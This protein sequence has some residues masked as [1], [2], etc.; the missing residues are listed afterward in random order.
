MEG[1]KY[2]CSP[3]LRDHATQKML[4]K[5]IAAGTF[6][7]VSSDH[8]PYRYDDTGKF[9][10]GSDIDFRK[11]ANGMP[12][13]EMRLPMMF[14]E[15]VLKGRIGLNQFVALSSTN[16]AKLYGMH[17]RKGT[18]SVG[19]D[20]DIA[21]W[22]PTEVRIAGEMHDNMDYNPFE[23]MEVTGWPVTVLGRGERIVDN[24][25]LIAKPG[26]GAFIAR[27]RTDLTGLSGTRLAETNLSSNFGA[28]VLK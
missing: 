15:G 12:G 10:A 22:D 25:E 19:A 23:G 11:I 21:I 24:G 18:L 27:D 8:A 20:A 4:W 16:A 13:I 2:I 3:P 7:V 26:D 5:H 1:A 9:A 17:P 6:S 14:S 28:E